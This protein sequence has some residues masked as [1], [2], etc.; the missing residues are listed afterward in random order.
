MH[1]RRVFAAV[2]VLTPLIAAVAACNT[3]QPT[4]AA[5]PAHTV[6]VTESGAP[7]TAATSGA[8]VAPTSADS[9]KLAPGTTRTDQQ[10]HRPVTGTP[11]K[12]SRDDANVDARDFETA[13]GQYFF[14]SPSGNVWCAI[15]VDGD[16][17]PPFGCQAASSV[18]A[19]SGVTCRNTANH[20]YAV[21]IDGDKVTQFCTSQGIFTAP[22]PRTLAYGQ[23]IMV[24][25]NSCTSTTA[26]MTCYGRSGFII[27]RDVNR[28]LP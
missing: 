5:E 11:T 28:V 25:G 23:T 27:S 4:P 16:G 7:D 24:R 22:S 2:V 15:R 20:S 19:S 14:R 10:Q 12:P 6:T 17:N 9:T 1:H 3:S 21:R 18:P 13:P 26:G 8:P